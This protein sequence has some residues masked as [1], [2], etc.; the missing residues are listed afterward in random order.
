M[1]TTLLLDNFDGTELLSSHVS[2]SGHTWADVT[3]KYYYPGRIADG[4]YTSDGEMS[5]GIS[6]AAIILPGVPVHVE[7]GF[8]LTGW[9][10]VSS[11][12]G[13][14][15]NDESYCEF[16]FGWGY[17]GNYVSGF[18]SNYREFVIAGYEAA[19]DRPTVTLAGAAHTLF[20]D[21]D[22]ATS[23][24]VTFNGVSA[25]YSVN[26][27]QGAAEF[28]FEQFIDHGSD[29]M[30][31]TSIKIFSDAG[32]SSGNFWTARINCTETA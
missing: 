3:G 17:Q 2:D 10:G 9:D 26:A 30:R 7:L 23:A 4:C 32:V 24:T 18:F 19:A 14:P 20:L 28:E 5:G 15:G 8:L 29:T 12:D 6:S 27:P 25:T 13:Y 31:L 11:G 1:P 16:Y 22:G 21:Y